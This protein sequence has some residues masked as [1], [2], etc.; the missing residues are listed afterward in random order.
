MTSGGDDGRADPRLASALAAYD[1]SAAAQARVHTALAGARVFL[2]LSAQALSTRTSATGLR[3]ESEAQISLVT[4]QAPS[5]ARALPAFLDGH[6]VARWRSG[7]RPLPLA[8]PLAC[9]AALDDGAAALLLDPLGAALAVQGSA[10]AELAAGRV[11]VAGAPLSVRRAGDLPGAL[12]GA[13]SGAGD[14]GTAD[15]P[16]VPAGLLDALARALRPEPVDAARLLAGPEGPLLAV[17]ARSPLG[18]AEQAALAER[19]RRRLGDDLPADGLDLAV[20]ARAPEGLRVPLR[21]GLLRR[22]R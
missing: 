21:R 20:V 11:P 4:L 16:P 7:V 17:T 1:G 12:S 5:G 14:R 18:P 22:V 3:E 19:V 13:V 9:Q 8:A 2:V 10:L 6:E 15:A